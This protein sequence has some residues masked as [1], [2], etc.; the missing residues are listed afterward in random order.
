MSY[1]GLQYIHHVFMKTLI[2]MTAF[3][4]DPYAG[5]QQCYLWNS[6]LPENLSHFKGPSNLNAS[7]RVDHASVLL[8]CHWKPSTL[9]FRYHQPLF[10]LIPQHILAITTLMMD[11]RNC[12][13]F[14]HLVCYSQFLLMKP[15]FGRPVFS[16]EG[17]FYGSKDSRKS[18]A[19]PI[20][21]AQ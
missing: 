13:T 2:M 15:A 21:T 11:N 8:L 16:L 4:A 1:W 3:M 17:P 5:K 20:L 12:S 19:V 18:L 10:K 9:S 14:P 6:T 7:S